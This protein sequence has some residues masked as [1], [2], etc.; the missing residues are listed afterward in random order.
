MRSIYSKGP[1][2]EHLRNEVQEPLKAAIYE[3][4]RKKGL[5][6]RDTVKAVRGM[7]ALPQPT[8]D[9]ENRIR[10]HN[11]QIMVDIR[12]EFFTFFN[13]KHYDK[14]LRAIINFAIIKIDFDSFY[15]SLLTWWVSEMIK[16]GWEFPDE[17]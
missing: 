8:K 2:Q 16:R 6:I 14:M 10:K 1:W 13:T 5:G 3:L 9:G 7:L 12:D 11:S 4:N 17:D 15:D